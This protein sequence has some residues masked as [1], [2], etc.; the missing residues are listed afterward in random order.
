[1]HWNNKQKQKSK[2]WYEPGHAIITEPDLF[3]WEPTLQKKKI[4]NHPSYCLKRSLYH[5]Y[6]HRWNNCKK[7]KH[8]NAIKL[9]YFRYT[10]SPYLL[11]AWHFFSLMKCFNKS[12]Q[13]KEESNSLCPSPPLIKLRYIDDSEM[14][15]IILVWK[16]NISTKRIAL[17]PC[18]EL[19]LCPLLSLIFPPHWYGHKPP[20]YAI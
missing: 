6:N 17:S 11:N 3:V 12:R 19:I 4:Y 10:Q 14:F 9:L 13:H 2:C 5:W 1:M 8:M 16:E 20:P 15:L 7:K 18:N